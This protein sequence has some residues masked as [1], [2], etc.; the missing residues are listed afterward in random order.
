MQK[1]KLFAGFLTALFLLPAFC[2]AQTISI[3]SGNGQ[4]VCPDCPVNPQKYVPL[5]VL[6]TDASANPVANA[7]VTW[8]TSQPGDTS[9]TATSTTNSAGQASYP[10]SGTNCPFAP[11]PIFGTSDF[12]LTTIVASAT[13]ASVTSSVTFY[14]TT[15]EPAGA[16][17]TAATISLVPATSPPVLT[18]GIPGATATPIVVSVEGENGGLSNIQISLV[19]DTTGLTIGCETQPGQQAGTVL[20]DSSGIATCTPLYGNKLGS[21][22]YTILIG[23]TYTSFSPTAFSIVAGPPSKI[24]LV[25]G[26]NQNV[27]VGTLAPASLTAQVTDAG[28]N[29]STGAAV[30]WAVTLGTATLSNIVSSTLSNG[31]VSAWVTPT[32][33]SSP[34]PTAGAECVQVTVSLASKTTVQ[35]V[36]TVNVNTVIT[37]MQTVAGNNQQALEGAAFAD[38]LIVQVNDN[39]TPVQGAT[40]NFAVTSGAAVLNV[41]S[42]ATNAQGQ[43]QVTATAGA[44]AGPVVITA[45]VKSGSTTYTQAFNLTV[46]PPGATITG[47]VNAAGFQSQFVSP[48]SLATIYGTGLATGLEGVASTLIAPQTQVNGVTV[49]FGGVLAPILY[50]A[51]VNGQQSASV[52][53]PCEVP[54]SAAVPPATVPMV[55]TVNGVASQP[56]PV[57]VLPVSPGIFQFKDSDGQTRAVLVRSDGS[58]ISVTNPARPGDTIRMFVT[59]LGQTTPAL[60]TDELDPLVL[61]SSNNWVPQALTVNA[62]VIVGVGNSGVLVLSSQYSADM[63]GVYEVDFQVPENAVATNNSPFAIVLYQ[64]TNAIYG[65]GSLIPIQ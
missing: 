65:N 12:Y 25:S 45:T 39:S 63:V 8:V 33:G 7:T 22:Y 16:G 21:G 30:K 61:D 37:A 1:L 64:G 14:E 62:G 23:V 42:A 38:P 60:F 6:V 31:D 54:S 4:L 19:S 10:C 36:F 24:N 3:Y 35:Y 2:P 43:A 59:G 57:T 58:F 9:V 55:V 20:T 11:L 13:V 50:V 34:C 48:C 18:G 15:A 52:Q 32:A 28:G 41:P 49:Q 47:I 5:V 40:V 29:P 46:N 51:N 26:N 27:N 44:T 17:T 53:V 56:F